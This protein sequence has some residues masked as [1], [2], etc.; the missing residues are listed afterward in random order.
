MLNIFNHE[1]INK[2]VNDIFY[3]IEDWEVYETFN[4]PNEYG[5]I[6]D[7]KKCTLI[8]KDGKFSFFIPYLFKRS[9]NLEKENG[10]GLIGDTREVFDIINNFDKKE[11]LLKIL[12]KKLKTDK[13]D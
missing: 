11:K 13:T 5:D 3:K 2:I 9:Y 10:Y 6:T 1:E 4:T 8:F 12:Y 7:Y